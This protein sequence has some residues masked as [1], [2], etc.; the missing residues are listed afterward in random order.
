[1]IPGANFLFVPMLF[2]GKFLFPSLLPWVRQRLSPFD[3]DTSSSVERDL[4]ISQRMLPL[5]LLFQ[6]PPSYTASVDGER[7][8]KV[9]SSTQPAPAALLQIQ[10][11]KS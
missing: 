8:I 11:V 1:M 6:S 2:C 3:S 4:R 10:I 9:F 5:I 7:S